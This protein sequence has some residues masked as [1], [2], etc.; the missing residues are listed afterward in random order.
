M[1][2]QA[3]T[4]VFTGNL[5]GP[6]ENPPVPSPGTGTT[7]V[8]Y[9]SVAHTLNVDVTFSGLVGT[10]TV[11]HIH[12]CVT[13][14]GTVGVATFPGTFP[15]FPAGVTAGSYNGTIDLTMLTSYTSGF[16]TNFTDG[17]AADAEATLIGNMVAGRSYLNVH[18]SFAGSGEIRDFLTLVPEPGTYALLG[19]AL[20]FLSVYRLR[21]KSA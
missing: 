9:D 6:N 14:P 18:S 1:A 4:L 16:L 8:T 13:P 17:T 5:T 19:G 12:C 10:T 21:K 15:G 11:A 3:A 20:A 7:V 2:S